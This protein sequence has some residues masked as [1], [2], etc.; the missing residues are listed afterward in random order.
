MQK[1]GFG[2]VSEKWRTSNSVMWCD[3]CVCV[4]VCVCVYVCV[5][6]L[7]W[8][9]VQGRASMVRH[10]RTCQPVR[11]MQSAR[12]QNRLSAVSH[13]RAYTSLVLNPTSGLTTCSLHNRNA[14]AGGYAFVSWSSEAGYQWS[15]PEDEYNYYRYC[16]RFPCRTFLF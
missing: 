16:N 15:V 12:P 14:T 8:W 1:N 3:V 9:M 11:Q 4:C 10:V 7:W 5:Y 6:V 13:T 2:C